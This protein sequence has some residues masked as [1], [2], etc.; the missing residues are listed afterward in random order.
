M[1]PN[2]LDKLIGVSL[3]FI[4]VFPFSFAA[5]FVISK[6]KKIELPDIFLFCFWVSTAISGFFIFVM[7]LSYHFLGVP[8]EKTYFFILTTWIFF[9][10]SIFFI[11]LFLLSKISIK[12]LIK[13]PSTLLFLCLIILNLFFYFK[14]A[15]VGV[16]MNNPWL[17]SPFEKTGV[18][19]LLGT[20]FVFFLT[21]LL[22]IKE[23]FQKGK[24]TWQNLSLLYNYFALFL[25]GIVSFITTFYFFPRSII[26]EI[27]Y[28]LIPYLVYLARKEELKYEKKS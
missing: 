18:Y 4:N 3:S 14:G 24:I 10:A 1:E 20:I 12:P 23:E 26:L 25:Y 22:I 17:Y 16:R 21:S 8:L 11:F 27:S 6:K 7:F 13:I 28:F 15:K 19:F 9:G 5:Y 2:F